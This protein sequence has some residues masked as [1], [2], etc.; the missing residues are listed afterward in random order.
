MN[1][2][3]KEIVSRGFSHVYA[4]KQKMLAESDCLGRW[5]HRHYSLFLPRKEKDAAYQQAELD[6]EQA[7]FELRFQHFFFFFFLAC[8][9]SLLVKTIQSLPLHTITQQASNLHFHPE[10]SS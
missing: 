2:M 7:S 3:M 5:E 10:S 6:S 9:A 1:K 4:T 8:L